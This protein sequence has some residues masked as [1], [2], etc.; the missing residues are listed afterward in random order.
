MNLIFKTILS[1]SLS[2][3]FLILLLLFGGG[4]LK[5]GSADSG[6]ITSG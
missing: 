1:L 3:A 5:K 4:I 6:S 2:G